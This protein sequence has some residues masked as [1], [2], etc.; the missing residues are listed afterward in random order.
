MTRR[1]GSSASPDRSRDALLQAWLDRHAPEIGRI[2]GRSNLLVRRRLKR[3][4]S[5]TTGLFPDIDPL[6]HEGGRKGKANWRAEPF[7]PTGNGVERFE[8]LLDRIGPLAVAIV[9]Q[10]MVLLADPDL[11]AKLQSMGVRPGRD[12][13]QLDWFLAKDKGAERLVTRFGEE[14]AKAL[15]SQAALSVEFLAVLAS[16]PDLNHRALAGFLEGAG[17]TARIQ[18]EVLGETPAES[19]W[20]QAEVSDED[21]TA[22]SGVVPMP[23]IDEILRHAHALCRY[24][25]GDDREPLKEVSQAQFQAALEALVSRWDGRGGR[26]RGQVGRIDLGRAMRV[27]LAHT[28]IHPQYY[29]HVHEPEVYEAAYADEYPSGESWMEVVVWF[30]TD[31]TTTIE[32]GVKARKLQTQDEQE[33]LS[34]NLEENWRRLIRTFLNAYV[35]PQRSPDWPSE[36]QSLTT[37]RGLGDIFDELNDAPETLDGERPEPSRARA[38]WDPPDEEPDLDATARAY[39]RDRDV[40]LTE[41]KEFLEFVL[42]PRHQRQPYVLIDFIVYFATK[43]VDDADRE[44]FGDDDSPKVRPE[45]PQSRRVER[46]DRARAWI[47]QGLE[48]VLHEAYERIP[49]S[50]K[51][52]RERADLGLLHS[53]LDLVAEYSSSQPGDK[54]RLLVQEVGA[55]IRNAVVRATVLAVGRKARNYQEDM[56]DE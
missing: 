11:P 34:Q 42:H 26:P 37:V 44:I 35:D 3:L 23:D 5:D 28:L 31:G 2:G 40:H 7:S 9:G 53:E 10:S 12:R 20:Q 48:P 56:D 38:P 50:R 27:R 25:C 33:L 46:R 43:L 54:D 21:A 45:A 14:V 41:T 8:V 4:V 15:G 16:D 51:V 47:Q 6:I 29:K 17:E 55:V 19:L 1:T 36:L 49:S 52:Q 18:S 39:W 32:R 24:E 13:G 30:E 22:E